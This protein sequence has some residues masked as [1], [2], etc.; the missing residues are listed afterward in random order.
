MTSVIRAFLQEQH[1]TPDEIQA[2]ELA[3]VEAS[4]N[5]IQYVRTEAR[6]KEIDIEVVFG[7]ERLEVR[8][9]DHTAGF[10]LPEHQTLPGP[11]AS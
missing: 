7:A 1:A 6:D 2:V 3:I 9:K 10:E 8:I 4:N 5:A 11:E